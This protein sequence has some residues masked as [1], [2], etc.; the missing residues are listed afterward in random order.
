MGRVSC[1]EAPDVEH[2]E[3]SDIVPVFE[4]GENFRLVAVGDDEPGV[5]GSVLFWVGRQVGSIGVNCP[6]KGVVFDSDV[7]S[8]CVV[9][10]SSRTWV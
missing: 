10:S 9:L 2:V 6:D 1:G 4:G 8:V 5:F 3:P 7:H